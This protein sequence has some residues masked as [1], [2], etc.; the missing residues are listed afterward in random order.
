VLAFGVVVLDVLRYGLGLPWAGV[1]NLLV[2]WLT[3]HQLGFL[4]SDGTLDRAGVPLA[5]AALGFGV[6]VA[7]TL[8]TG[9]YPVLMVGL[10]GEPISNLAPPN[11]ALLAH[12]VGLTGLALL[13]RD[14]VER[15]L[16]RPYPWAAVV[17]GNSVIMTVF[18]WHLSAVF[19]VQGSLL[20]LGAHT[21]T[22]GSVAWW[23][24][25]P[26]WVLLCTVPLVVLVLLFRRAEHQSA[27]GT[28]RPQP[29]AGGQTSAAAG[30]ALTALGIFL[31]SQLG[32][33][34]LVAGETE[35]VQSILLP[36]WLPVVLVVAGAL[37][38]RLG[39]RPQD[40]PSEGTG[41]AGATSVAG[42]GPADAPHPEGH[43]AGA[44]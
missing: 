10:P 30:V 16:R 33:D 15:W 32:L 35:E 23:A 17:L 38:L 26:L 27:R 14:P 4:W 1:A 25:L 3:V 37:L 19:L 6:T 34:G 29:R 20:L 7:L 21:P 8:V 24:F 12:A 28:E 22:A 44:A 5:A 36:V 39:R 13:F 2:V 41:S 43:P 9:W 31:A 11:V 42:T 18:C 40:A